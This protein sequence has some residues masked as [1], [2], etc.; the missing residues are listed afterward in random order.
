MRCAIVLSA[1]FLGGCGDES[2][3]PAKVDLSKQA[4]PAAGADMLGDQMKSA[5]LKGAP[6]AKTAAPEKSAT[7]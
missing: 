5:K 3:E 1:V 4:Q 6:T 2:D 7:K